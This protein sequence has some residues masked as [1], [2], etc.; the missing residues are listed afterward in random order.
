MDVIGQ[1]QSSGWGYFGYDD[2]GSV[3]QMTDSAGALVYMANYDPYG[4]PLELGGDFSTSLG[5]TGEM[6]DPTGMVYLRARYMSPQIG[7]FLTK[8]PFEGFRE[9]VMSRNGY[10]Y[11]E[12]NPV[13][14]TDPSGKFVFM[15]F[16]AKAAIGAGAG[17]VLTAIVYDA[18]ARGDC[19]CAYQDW[20]QQTDRAQFILEGAF[21]GGVGGGLFEMGAAARV[22]VGAAGVVTGAQ[23][24]A[25]RLPN[26]LEDIIAGRE[27]NKCEALEAA[28]GGLGIVVGQRLVR[29][30]FTGAVREIRQLPRNIQRV[31]DSLRGAEN[32][33]QPTGGA[34]DVAGNR[35]QLTVQTPNLGGG[36]LLS[37]FTNADGIRG[38]TGLAP[39]ELVVGR[40]VT[41]QR[42]TFGRGSNSFLAYAEG[43]IFATDLG[44][45]AT[46]GQLQSIGVFG[47]RQN[48]VIQFSQEAAFSAGARTH[49]VRNNIYTIPGN[50]Q[51]SG[52]FDY[53]VQRLR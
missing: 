52:G 15:Y 49:L 1:Q 45:D 4:V 51:L 37:H 9:R 29:S 17:A 40:P 34:G 24:V 48:Y 44:P 2:L 42:L 23:A 50:S 36:T 10:T 41:V 25:N 19:G 12:G 6:T 43:D 33:A 8:D 22:V 38:I 30:N 3:R 26:I 7:M 46:M 5:F 47:D 20:T 31:A 11:V 39:E 14:Y 27:I 53:I 21:W 16:L 32:S 18:A 28:L 35:P 13:N